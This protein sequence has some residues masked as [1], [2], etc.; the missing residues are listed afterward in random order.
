MDENVRF[1]SSIYVTWGLNSDFGGSERILIKDRFS[2][3]PLRR[4]PFPPPRI[5]VLSRS[6]SSLTQPL[7]SQHKRTQ[8]D[9]LLL[10]LLP[11]SRSLSL[12]PRKLGINKS[13]KPRRIENHEISSEKKKKQ[14][15]DMIVSLSCKVFARKEH[16][17][18]AK[19]VSTNTILDKEERRV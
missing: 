7:P 1:F 3:L 4:C 10:L 13:Q 17:K 5:T 6:L 9:R 8:Q 14:F 12:Q 19:D 2:C 11:R 18:N 15:R 16:R